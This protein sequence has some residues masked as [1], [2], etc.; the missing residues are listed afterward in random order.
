MEVRPVPALYCCYL[1]RSHPSPGALYVGSTPNP[2]RRLQQHNGKGKGGALRTKAHRPWE[3]NC[4]VTG[5][6][7]KIAALQFE[8]AWQNTHL[9]KRITPEQRITKVP[10]PKKNRK[11]RKRIPRPRFTLRDRLQN[12]HLL[13]RVPSFARWPLNVRFF[14]QKL[15]VEWQQAVGKL[16]DNPSLRPGINVVLDVKQTG[17]EIEPDTK[18]LST[19][20]KGKRRKDAVGKGGLTGVDVGYGR[21]KDHIRKSLSL[22]DDESERRCAVCDQRLNDPGMM[23]TVCPHGACTAAC[24]LTCL[25]KRFL[26]E[27]DSLGSL[28]PICGHCP[29]CGTVTQWSDF[30]QEMTLRTRGAK[31][32]TRLMKHSSLK[33]RSAG[34]N[35]SANP[36]VDPKDLDE[37]EEVPDDPLPD[38][39]LPQIDDGEDS[40][41]VTSAASE[42]S[43]PVV[44]PRK[45][46]PSVIEDSE[47]DKA[48]M[49]D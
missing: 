13:L 24:H 11:G 34:I 30:V 7:S 25:S 46:L 6:P 10:S 36:S 21:F 23:A 38:D 33:D 39:W 35:T 8:W 49:L 28:L 31:E 32:L 19:Y 3:M 9:T 12:L 45:R 41:S 5:F 47:W 14:C 37:D 27:R 26:S 4:I 1:L 48:E 43:T 16:A 15:W 22:L 42:A 2:P 18:S 29:R 40:A 44:S 17:A 20:E